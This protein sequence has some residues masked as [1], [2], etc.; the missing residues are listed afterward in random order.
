M[1]LR[2]GKAA[3]DYVGV[4]GARVLSEKMDGRL[5][6]ARPYDGAARLRANRPFGVDLARLRAGFRR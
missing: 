4:Q 5:R 3:L 6:Q 2:D 1:T